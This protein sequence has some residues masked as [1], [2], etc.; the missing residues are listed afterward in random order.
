MYIDLFTIFLLIFLNGFFVAAE[1]SLLASR[2]SRLD[3][4]KKKNT[5]SSGLVESNLKNVNF[6]ITGIQVAITGINIAVGWIGER[7][8]NI[9][10]RSYF[11]SYLV[12]FPFLNNSFFTG[13]I[14]FFAITFLLMIF[15]ELIPKSISMINPERASLILAFPLRVYSFLFEP[16]IT[17]INH[18]TDAILRPLG[19]NNRKRDERFSEEELKI[20]INQS[21]K[22]GVIPP[23]LQHIIF[24]SL[25][26]KNIKS[27]NA[28]YDYSS[29]ISFSCDSSIRDI[30]KE[31][32]QKRHSHLRYLV[33]NKNKHDL[34]GFI[35][36]ADLIIHGYTGKN[37]TLKEANII[38]KAVPVDSE[39]TLDET[40][41]RMLI[42]NTFVAIIHENSKPTGAVTINAITKELTRK[43]N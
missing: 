8:V 40:L 38:K 16:V 6:F 28:M 32:S 23:S 29:I 25:R 37:N 41:S 27:K 9:F 11:Q 4:M 30:M 36:T 7:F 18:V 14:P 13:I 3:A 22:E 34:V 1:I 31:I 39:S 5:F 19:L 21:V 24:N 17:F 33:H 42:N 20:I 10:L 26:L 2:K 43:F 12:Q 15:G 35:E